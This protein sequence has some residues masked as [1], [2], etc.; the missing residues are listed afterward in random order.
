[1]IHTV[2]M[3]AVF[4]AGAIDVEVQTLDGQKTAGRL[5]QLDGQHVAVDT[6]AGAATFEVSKLVSVSSAAGK[7]TDVPKPQVIVELIDDTRLNAKSFGTVKGQAEIELVSG[8]MIKVPTKIIRY[9]RFVEA[10]P[11]Q[12]QLAKQW[13]EMLALKPG[14]DLLVTRKKG[15]LDYTEG[16]VR[17]IN[18]DR[19]NFSLDG[20]NIEVKRP[21]VEA[22]LYYRVTEPALP[23]PQC[24]VHLLGNAQIAAAYI[25]LKGDLISLTTAASAK[26]EV[27][28]ESLARLDYSVGKL[29]FLSDLEAELTEVTPYFGG[30]KDLAAYV[31]AFAPRRDRNLDNEPLKLAGKTYEKGLA[32]HSQTRQTYRLAGKYRQFM[33]IAGI[34]DAISAGGS[35]QLQISGDGKQL[36]EG[37][38]KAGDEPRLLEIDVTGVKRLELFVGFDDNLDVG[39]H[40][41]LCEAKVMK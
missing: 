13:D 25:E 39:D 26:F 20:E 34:D 28:I 15:S 1:V 30:P 11:T 2:L 31:D 23:V 24:V 29:Q 38:I 9:A 8:G 10:A 36:W 27:P 16:L 33:A 14:G 12:G 5:T 22:I 35:V 17:D 37:T 41:D 3:S 40:L 32:L 4:L 21:R 7:G 19:V 6:T 18:A